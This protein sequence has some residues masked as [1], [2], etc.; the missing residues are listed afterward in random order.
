MTPAPPV[1][2]AVIGPVEPA[3]LTAWTAHYR[4]LGITDFRLAFHFPDH[5]PAPWRDQLLATAT[6]LGLPPAKVSTGPWHEHTNT[7]LRDTLREQAGPGWHLLADSDELHTYPAPLTEVIAAAETAG[8]PVVGGLMLD[9]VAPDGRLAHWRPETGLD[10]AF[11]LGGHLTHRLLHGDPRKIVLVRSEVVVAS[12]NH[13]APGHKPDLDTLACVHHFKWRAG[14]LNDLRRRV[15]NFTS[16][17]WAEHTP[18]VRDEAGRLLEHID[19]H[20]GRIDV[21]DPRLGFR[22]VTLDGPPARWAAEARGIV[23][24]WRPPATKPRR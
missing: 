6:E 11:P 9:R 17:A 7:D 22:R 15:E 16:G 1:M 2:V 4:A 12:G 18:A 3:L 19:R 20:H 8:R 5:F 24:R 21:A 23:T 14:V 13:R 10:R